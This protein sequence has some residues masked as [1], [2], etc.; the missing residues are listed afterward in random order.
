MY[1]FTVMPNHVY[2]IVIIMESENSLVVGAHGRAPLRRS[3]RSLASLIAGHK[4]IVT[5]QINQIRNTPGAPVWQRNY[6]ERII[7][8]DGEL[9]RILAAAHGLA[10][11]AEQFW[12]GIK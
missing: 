3:P 2:A 11:R 12:G 8:N 7:R 4:S 9:S 6:W 10:N 5:K 1:E